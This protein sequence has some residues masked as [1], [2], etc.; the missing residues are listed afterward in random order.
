MAP[1][2]IQMTDDHI[3]QRVA[4]VRDALRERLKPICVRGGE[5]EVAG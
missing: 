5:P 2:P 1:S 3:V 4:S